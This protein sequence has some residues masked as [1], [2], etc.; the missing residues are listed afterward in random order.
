M[1]RVGGETAWTSIEDLFERT[2]GSRSLADHFPLLKRTE[3]ERPEVKEF[4][5]RAFRIMAIS[6][7]LPENI[8]PSIPWILGVM[9]PGLLPGAWGNVVPPLTFEDRHQLINQY[10]AASP[11]AEFEDGT[12]LLEMG[13]GFP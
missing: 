6:K 10:L 9:I 3:N 1:L 11:W 7:V 12:V 13:C 5:E 8:P 2:F 4:I